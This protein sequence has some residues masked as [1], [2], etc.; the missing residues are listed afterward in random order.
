MDPSGFTN[1]VITFCRGSLGFQDAALL[2]ILQAEVHCWW[3]EIY[4]SRFTTP[5]GYRLETL[6]QLSCPSCQWWMDAGCPWPG[7]C[8]HTDDGWP[9]WVMDM[10]VGSRPKKCPPLVSRTQ[11]VSMKSI[12]DLCLACHPL[13]DRSRAVFPLFPGFTLLHPC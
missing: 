2:L 8:L 5:I 3:P 13:L 4:P 11:M 12:S 10:L 6:H 7:S 9:I 1:I